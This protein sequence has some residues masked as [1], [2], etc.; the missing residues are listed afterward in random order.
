LIRRK[1][2]LERVYALIS[3]FK[4]WGNEFEKQAEGKENYL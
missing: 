3:K 4:V 1:A 2:N